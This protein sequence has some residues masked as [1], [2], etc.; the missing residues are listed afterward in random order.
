MM[1]LRTEIWG[2]DFSG[3]EFAG[4]KIWLSRGMV[5]NERLVIEACLR[6]TELSGG[7]KKRDSAFK[8]LVSMIRKANSAVLGFDF[9][10]S[11]PMQLT[12]ALTYGE[13]LKS[14]ASRYPTPEQFL[15]DCRAN[16][17]GKE[18]KRETD[19]KS[20]TPFSPYNIRLYRQ[21]YFGIRDVLCPLVLDHAVSVLPMQEPD[22]SKPWLIEIC[23]ATLLKSEGLYFPYKGRQ[24]EKE[25]ARTDILDELE[26][27]GLVYLESSKLHSLILKDTEGDALDS[28]IAAI[29][30]HRAIVN[31]DFLI[32]GKE[33]PHLLEGFVYGLT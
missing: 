14:F 9:P 11:I 18:L 3:A 8:A 31:P 13:F 28:V 21:T 1:N 6:V 12:K 16:S 27:R 19:S 17:N 23:P 4:K 24:E 15:L 22:K 20:K 29:A 32:L 2:I 26:K 30:V 33:H 10:F 7:G 25:K 5:K